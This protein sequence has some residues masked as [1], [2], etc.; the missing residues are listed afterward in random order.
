MGKIVLLTYDTRESRSIS[1]A[2]KS[3]KYAVWQ[4]RT[5]EEACHAA[6]KENPD[7]FIIDVPS[8]TISFHRLKK[9]LGRDIP[10]TKIPFIIFLPENTAEIKI[11]KMAAAVEFLSKPFEVNTLLKKTAILIEAK[12]R[13]EN[14]TPDARQRKTK[15]EEEVLQFRKLIENIEEE[16]Y[17][18]REEIMAFRNQIKDS[19]IETGQMIVELVEER[20]IFE[21]GHSIRVSEYSDIIGKALRLPDKQREQLIHASLLHDIGKIFISPAILGK[22][23][24]LTDWEY[25]VIRSHPIKGQRLLQSLTDMESIA[26]TIL[27]HHEQP[28]GKGYYRKKTR[29]AP[30]LSKIIAVAEAFDAMTTARIQGRHMSVNEALEQ[31]KEGKGKKF[32]KACVEALI[33]HIKQGDT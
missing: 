2:L 24:A 11:L 33:S 28:D 14:D 8:P 20:D 26:T 27:L 22:P 5:V 6:R 1:A 4:T 19:Y 12:K 10:F 31:L 15:D 29:E 9:S 18:S 25:E 17:Q 13:A 23:S 21:K 32:D 16:S 30:K 7:L 3:S